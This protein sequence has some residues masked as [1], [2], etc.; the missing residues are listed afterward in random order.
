MFHEYKISI[1]TNWTKYINMNHGFDYYKN[2]YMYNKIEKI[3]ILIILS[4]F[5]CVSTFVSGQIL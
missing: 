4:K 1:L 2:G 5:L 3:I